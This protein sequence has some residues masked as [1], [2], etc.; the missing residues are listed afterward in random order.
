SV[1][2]VS[3]TI[4]AVRCFRIADYGDCQGHTTQWAYSKFEKQC[5]RFDYSGCGGNENRFFSKFECEL[6]CYSLRIEATTARRDLEW[7]R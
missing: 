2:L 1:R 6:T 4:L 7:Y 5:T 3:D